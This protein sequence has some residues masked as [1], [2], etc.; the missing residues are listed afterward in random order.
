MGEVWG[1]GG[2]GCTLTRP[3]AAWPAGQ[4]RPC[5]VQGATSQQGLRAWGH[6]LHGAGRGPSASRVPELLLME[7]RVSGTLGAG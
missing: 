4:L 5:R 1:V 6:Y 7:L 2:V 3:Q